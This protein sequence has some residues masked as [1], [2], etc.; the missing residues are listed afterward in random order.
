MTSF[1]SS[2]PAKRGL[3]RMHAQRARYM[4]CKGTPAAHLSGSPRRGEHLS[5]A[6]LKPRERQLPEKLPEKWSPRRA[7]PLLVLFLQISSAP[8]VAGDR[9]LQQTPNVPIADHATHTHRR[10]RLAHTSLI[11]YASRTPATPRSPCSLFVF[12]HRNKASSFTASWSTKAHN[13]G[14]FARSGGHL[15]AYKVG[16]QAS[17]CK[18][19]G[20]QGA[21]QT[22]I[23]GQT[24]WVGQEQRRSP[25]NVAP[26]DMCIIRLGSCTGLSLVSC[27]W[28]SAHI[29]GLRTCQPGP[30][31]WHESI[32]A[33]DGAHTRRTLCRDYW[34][35][36]GLLKRRSM[37][38]GGPRRLTGERRLLIAGAAHRLAGTGRE[39]EWSG[40]VGGIDPCR[41]AIGYS[42]SAIDFTIQSCQVWSLRRRARW[43]WKATSAAQ[44]STAGTMFVA[45]MAATTGE[46]TVVDEGQRVDVW[47]PGVWCHVTLAASFWSAAQ[48]SGLHPATSSA[49][50]RLSSPPPRFLDLS[51]LRTVSTTTTTIYTRPDVPM[52]LNPTVESPIATAPPPEP[53]ARASGAGAPSQ[54]HDILRKTHIFTNPKVLDAASATLAFRWG[55]TNNRSRALGHPS[56]WRRRHR[57]QDQHAPPPEVTTS[58]TAAVHLPLFPLSRE[59]VRVGLEICV[60]ELINAILSEN[61]EEHKPEDARTRGPVGSGD[62]TTTRVLPIIFHGYVVGGVTLVGA[63]AHIALSKAQGLKAS[64][65]PPPS[66]SAMALEISIGGPEDLISQREHPPHS[67]RHPDALSSDP[68]RYRWRNPRIW[69]H[70]QRAAEPSSQARD[71]A[72][73]TN[74]APG[75]LLRR[76][77]PH[78]HT[79]TP[80]CHGQWRSSTSC[81]PA[82][83]GD[84]GHAWKSQTTR[85]APQRFRQDHRRCGRAV[86]SLRIDTAPLHKALPDASKAGSTS[87]KNFSHQVRGE[88]M[89]PLPPCLSGSADLAVLLRRSRLMRLS[90]QRL[91]SDTSCRLTH[92]LWPTHVASTPTATKKWPDID[93]PVASANT[94]LDAGFKTRTDAGTGTTAIGAPEEE[95]E[96]EEAGD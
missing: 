49:I 90:R 88:Q 95:E 46:T 54:V 82:A 30:Y 69:P 71:R 15:R 5:S 14:A 67:K 25:F 24:S 64:L 33:L 75:M 80:V 2:R 26:G 7:G 9:P 81:T 85:H 18:R 41:T 11:T 22:F 48:F 51:G 34:G 27:L 58:L 89:F 92:A 35:L 36:L 44:G 19:M 94:R 29:A 72:G 79:P 53:M 47:R 84:A 66:P 55:D 74:S 70:H 37:A 1:F 12:A 40:S 6:T 16:S 4:R 10:P 38:R 39:V 8:G 63:S 17:H 20:P 59:S 68:T 13:R 57:E 3:F 28:T 21:V 45:A 60:D 65:F 23:S 78:L 50:P 56:A 83:P 77:S 52:Q 42:G 93:A 96:E 86:V 43:S 76:P 73:H 62:S 87:Y 31:K 32:G 61:D 91:S